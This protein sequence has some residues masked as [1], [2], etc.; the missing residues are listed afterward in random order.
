MIISIALIA[1]VAF[2]GIP[3]WC[4]VFLM[5]TLPIDLVMGLGIINILK[6]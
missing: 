5:M 6:D 2:W 1:G 3:A 4:L